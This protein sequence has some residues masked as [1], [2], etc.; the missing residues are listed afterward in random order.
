MVATRSEVFLDDL[1]TDDCDTPVLGANVLP[2]VGTPLAEEGPNQYI[3]PWIVKP[4]GDG[5]YVA[6]IG[7][8]IADKTKFSSSPLKTTQFLDEVETAQRY[9]DE[10]TRVGINKIVLVT[11]YQY[12]NDLALAS[13][14]RAST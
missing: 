9:V 14:V 3:R 4:Y 8:D 6:Y 2:K 12:A 5:E 13:Q 7:L 11:H 10:M 1:A